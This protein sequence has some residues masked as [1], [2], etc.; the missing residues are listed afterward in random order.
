MYVVFAMF[1]VHMSNYFKMYPYGSKL[2]EGGVLYLIKVGRSFNGARERTR[3]R[4]EVSSR[5]KMRSTVPIK[6][7]ENLKYVYLRLSCTRKHRL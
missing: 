4:P 7:E 6:Y 5:H 2:T 3:T 1:T